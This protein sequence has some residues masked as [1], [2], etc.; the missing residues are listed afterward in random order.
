MI[1]FKVGQKVK[2]LIYGVDCVVVDLYENIDDILYL[3]VI[4]GLQLWHR[5]KDLEE[6]EEIAENKGII[7]VMM[8][9]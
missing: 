2:S 4:N 1:K 7:E 9:A 5:L 8:D 6:L 3:V